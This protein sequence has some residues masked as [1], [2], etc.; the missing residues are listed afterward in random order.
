M[1]CNRLFLKNL[2]KKKKHRE[3][4]AVVKDASST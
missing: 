1:I 3:V 2:K 4:E